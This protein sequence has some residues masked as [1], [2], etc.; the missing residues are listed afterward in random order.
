MLVTASGCTAS[1]RESRNPCHRKVP[2]VVNLSSCCHGRLHR[3]AACPG[4]LEDCLR[5]RDDA[6]TSRYWVSA[7]EF[8]V[9]CVFVCD[10]VCLLAEPV[11]LAGVYRFES[12]V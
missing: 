1:V 12:G 6:E 9:L 8:G 7:L 3:F 2:N 5:A 11:N 4:D 10:V